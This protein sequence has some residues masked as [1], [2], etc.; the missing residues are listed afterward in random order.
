ML[1]LAYGNLATSATITDA[2]NTN[3]FPFA[4]NTTTTSAPP[5][6]DGKEQNGENGTPLLSKAKHH[7]HEQVEAHVE[8][9]VLAGTDLAREGPAPKGRI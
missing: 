6:D 8:L 3:V 2:A 9:P 7:V 5:P 1:G 4:T